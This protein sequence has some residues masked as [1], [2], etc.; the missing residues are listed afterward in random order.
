V[1]KASIA[2]VLLALGIV[3]LVQGGYERNGYS[4]GWFAAN[5][6]N[7]NVGYRNGRTT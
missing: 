1:C 3:S 7:V 4:A 6:N 5:L 2:A